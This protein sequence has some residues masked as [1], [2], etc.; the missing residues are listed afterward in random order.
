MRSLSNICFH[1]PAS[2]QLFCF[3]NFNASCGC[4][5]IFRESTC[6]LYLTPL[7]VSLQYSMLY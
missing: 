4:H 5:Y 2:S 7:K 6:S 1:T 3:C